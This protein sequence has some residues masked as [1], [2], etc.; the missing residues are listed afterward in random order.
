[1]G[2]SRR[3]FLA[4]TAIGMSVVTTSCT[5]APE[6][7]A[8][9][10]GVA[11]ASEV[12]DKW[13]LVRSE[14]DLSDEY[15]HMSA[16]L[17]SSH[18]RRVQD[19][20]ETYRRELNHNPVGYLVQNN[21]KLQA[22]ARE[23]AAEYLECDAG[24]VALTDSTTMGLG[25]LYGGLRLEPAQEVL[26]TSN[27]YFATHEALRA[28]SD[29]TGASMREIELYEHGENVSEEELVHRVINA[30]APRT[31]A[32]AL[33]WVHSST[34]L[35][36][37]LAQ[38]AEGLQEIN[39]NRDENDRV[40]LCVDGVHGFGVESARMKELGADFFAAGC[41]KWLFGPRGTGVLWGR[42]DAWAAVRP[43][44]PSF[45]DD[46]VWQSWLE[47]RDPD[48]PS[49]AARVTPGGFKAFEHQWALPEAFEFHHRIGTDRIATRTHALARQLKE[50][51]A[52]MPHVR[53]ITPMDEGL[54][55]GIVCFDVEGMRP[56]SVV[57]RL[58]DRRI[59]AT[60]TPYARMHAR[61]TPSILNT[62]QEIERALEAVRA[63]T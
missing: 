38:I 23:A 30:V 33:T 3:R 53:L 11:S 49:T 37:P 45:T 19:A 16:L 55:A 5:R 41:H 18:P 17:I 32:V 51:L 54:S 4:Q 46:V 50:G 14:F 35:K 12:S 9:N 29:R 36:M 48:G 59:I 34:G 42:N 22:R 27:D 20:I 7:Q 26:T 13:G 15:V 44:I 6:D 8:L 25:L 40:L 39:R 43:T 2:I 60:V 63:V 61:L 62:A 24:E 1:M 10:S 47:D 56:H 57:R 28:A 58:R 21:Q 31:R 52:R